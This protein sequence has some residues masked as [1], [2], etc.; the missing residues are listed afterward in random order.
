MSQTKE[1]PFFRIWYNSLVDGFGRFIL[2][3]TAAVYGT[4]VH[5][6]D[7]QKRRPRLFVLVNMINRKHIDKEKILERDLYVCAYCL[8]NAT[9]VEHVVPWAW[10]HCDDEDNLVASC[11][12]C[13]TIAGDKMF[14]SFDEK[15]AYILIKRS[16][17]KWTRKLAIKF[18]VFRCSNCLKVFKPLEYG[19]TN[20]LCPHCTEKEYS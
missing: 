1:T 3:Q 18:Q 2:P 20:F 7:R 19:A 9:E 10:S 11:R 8:G 16:G 5:Q 4:S 13:N 12:E 14:T 6:Q 17:K 15:R